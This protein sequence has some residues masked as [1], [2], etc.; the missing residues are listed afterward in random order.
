MN[1]C[2]APAVIGR[3]IAGA[4]VFFRELDTDG[5][6]WNVSVSEKAKNSCSQQAVELIFYT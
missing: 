2:G 4:L 3:S 6:H 5:L 1:S